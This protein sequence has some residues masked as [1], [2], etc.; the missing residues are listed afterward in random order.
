[1]RSPI[2]GLLAG[3]VGTSALNIVGYADMALRGRPAS[4][5]P[6][7]VATIFARRLGCELD[8]NRAE[9]FGMLLGYADGLTF[10]LAYGLLRPPLRDV[11]W[12]LGGCALA[13]ATLTPEFVAAALDAT[14]HPKRWGIEGWMAALA[15]RL[16]FGLVTAATHE[17]IA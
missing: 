2:A 10:G 3:A 13:L 4:R 5:V 11:P 6:D 1:V 7:A 14:D 15:P 12:V 8:A 9:G 16:A 17:A